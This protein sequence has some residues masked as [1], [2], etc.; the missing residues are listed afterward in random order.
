MLIALFDYFSYWLV[1]S[2]IS[3]FTPFTGLGL[4]NEF[5][6]CLL[7]LQVFLIYVILRLCLRVCWWLYYFRLLVDLVIGCCLVGYLFSGCL[8]VVGF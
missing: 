4:R 1:C 6:A 8:S 5:V 7:I 2:C 3:V